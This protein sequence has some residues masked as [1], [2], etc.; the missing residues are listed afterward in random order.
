MKKHQTVLRSEGQC[1]VKALF[2]GRVWALPLPFWGI[3]ELNFPTKG[4][5]V[6][7]R[8]MNSSRFFFSRD[9]HPQHLHQ[10]G[11]VGSGGLPW[12]LV[13]GA[14]GYLKPLR[15]LCVCLKALIIKTKEKHV[16]LILQ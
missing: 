13:M 9:N 11:G 14:W 5:S 12:K 7:F 2:Q 15:W 1:G 8:Q 3:L 10:G 16:R 4:H 6:H